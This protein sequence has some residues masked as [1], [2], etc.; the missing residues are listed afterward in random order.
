M[1]IARAL[2]NEPEIVLADE[3]TG[4]LDTGTEAEI[5]ELLRN[6]HEQRKLT[7]LVATHDETVAAAAQRVVRLKDGQ[8]DGED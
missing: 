5:I 2:M 6:L 4:N 7:L 3:P 1:A 8:I